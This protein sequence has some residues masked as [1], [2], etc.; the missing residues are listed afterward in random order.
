MTRKDYLIIASAVAKMQSLGE[1]QLYVADM[2]AS[3]LAKTNTRFDREK[4]MKACGVQQ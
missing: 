1:N 2:L 3:E 4:F